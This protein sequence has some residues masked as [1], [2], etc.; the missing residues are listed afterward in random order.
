MEP[1]GETAVADPQGDDR[2]GVTRRAVEAAV[3]RPEQHQPQVREHRARRP[4]APAAVLEHLALAV[5]V[6]LQLPDRVARG[7][8]GGHDVP[9]RVAL[10]VLVHA[11]EDASSVH[12]RG[13]EDPRAVGVRSQ[14]PRDAGVGVL[15]EER[16]RGGAQRV[17]R[18]PAG[19]DHQCRAIGSG[20]LVPGG[21]RDE[22]AVGRDVARVLPRIGRDGIL[23]G[24]ADFPTEPS[25]LE[26]HRVEV[27]VPGAGVDGLT[28]HRRRRGHRVTGREEPG[29]T[30]RLDRRPGQG[31]PAV[32]G[33]LG[34]V[35]VARPVP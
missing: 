4:H 19:E 10:A 7:E 8:A 18:V 23:R 12:H 3:G 24:E 34:V 2:V 35:A 5:H 1:P 26:V 13:G 21:R 31:G 20:R 29:L 25:G 9:R 33:V 6:G 32:E 28:D 17:E 14:R 30:Q 16:T 15:P 11:E 27:V 22:P